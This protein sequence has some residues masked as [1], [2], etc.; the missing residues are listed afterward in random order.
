MDIERG[1]NEYGGDQ[2]LSV[3]FVL[4]APL[5]FFVGFLPVKLELV[6]KRGGA[7]GLSCAL[8]ELSQSST[9]SSHFCFNFPPMHL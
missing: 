9:F 7:L 8:S 4:N 5:G 6:T 3:R 1:L 2:A